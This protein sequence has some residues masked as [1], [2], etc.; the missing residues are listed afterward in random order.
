MAKHHFP[1]P[2]AVTGAGVASGLGIGI[3]D[4][5]ASI[6]A[7]KHGL[8]PLIDSGLPV[9]PGMETILCGW[10]PDRSIFDGRRYGAAGNAA[11][12]VAKEAVAAAGW[13]DHEIRDAWLYVGTSRGN[14]GE[15]AGTWK[16]RR[17]VRKFAA[18]NTMHS[19]IAA[20]VSLQLGLEGPWQV[21]TNG[22]AAGLDAAGHA[23]L[24]VAMGWTQR[25]VAVA[26]DLPLIV[27]LLEDFAATGVLSRSGPNN[28][29][30]TD[31]SGFHPGEGIAAI[32]L[33]SGNARPAW[34][35]IRAYA[36][37]S[38]AHDA[39]ALPPDGRPLGSLINALAGGLAPDQVVGI[40]PHA[41]GTAAHRVSESASLAGAFGFSPAFLSPVPSLHILKPFTGH[42]LGAS[43]LV[44]AALL[45][46]F[47]RLGSLPPNLPGL[48]TPS[49]GWDLPTKS[50]AI[51]PGQSVLKIAAGMGGHNAALLLDAVHSHCAL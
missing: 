23:A 45:A 7:G 29:Y 42:T 25:A 47:L 40:C 26:V 39:V 6:S 20:A 15:W 35:N 24:A 18:S 38:D 32:T 44:D 10:V 2:V 36:A 14:A 1:Q 21:L 19:E 50:K 30:H 34:C 16:S 48:A 43:G 5:L 31:T 13:D 8:R 41:T 11:I 49:P 22:C 46:G 33:E 3:K 12:I 37:N 9:P 28:P 4:S 51:R 27:P 17:P